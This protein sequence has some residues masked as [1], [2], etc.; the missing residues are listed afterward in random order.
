MLLCTAKGREGGG[1]GRRERDSYFADRVYDA[2][3]FGP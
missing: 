1:G 2:V 3:L